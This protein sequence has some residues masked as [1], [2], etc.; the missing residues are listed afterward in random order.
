MVSLFNKLLL[1]TKQ[2]NKE[3]MRL[4]EKKPSN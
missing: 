3:E 2:N 4:V 1:K